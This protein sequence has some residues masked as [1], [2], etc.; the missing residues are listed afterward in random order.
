M[1]TSS[2]DQGSRTPQVDTRRY[3]IIEQINLHFFFGG[4]N[5]CSGRCDPHD[6]QGLFTHSAEAADLNDLT[7]LSSPRSPPRRIFLLS[8]SQSVIASGGT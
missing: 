2:N 4:V 8:G 5:R 3:H 7:H 6:S 1:A